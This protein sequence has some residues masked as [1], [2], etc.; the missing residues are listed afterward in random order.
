METSGE[1]MAR[2]KIGNQLHTRSSRAKLAVDKEPYWMTLEKA[3]ALGYRKGKTSG[4]WVARYYDPLL[5]PSKRY[6]PL[7]T[8]DDPR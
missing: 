1:L 6:Q 5:K 7:G 4:E 3:R 2:I 8:A